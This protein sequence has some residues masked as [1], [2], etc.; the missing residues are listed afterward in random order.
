MGKF[1]YEDSKVKLC[2]QQSATLRLEKCRFTARLTDLLPMGYRYLFGGR[3][4]LIGLLPLHAQRLL[5]TGEGP[6]DALL[7]FG[8]CAD[9]VL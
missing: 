3:R 2:G 1:N 6:V 9:V 8:L 5:Q 7:P 4:L